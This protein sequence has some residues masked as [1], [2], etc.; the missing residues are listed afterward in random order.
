VI[1]FSHWGCRQSSGG[2]GVIGDVLK[3]KGIPYLIL[4]GDGADP[5][6]YSPGQTRTRLEAFLEMLAEVQRG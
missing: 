4:P 3:R 6:N 5:D 1:H 2:A